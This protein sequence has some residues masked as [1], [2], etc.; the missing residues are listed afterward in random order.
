[1]HTAGR[2]E[3]YIVSL[4]GI[5]K[6]QCKLGSN[7]INSYL[8]TKNKRFLPSVVL[9]CDHCHQSPLSLQNADTCFVVSYYAS[10]FPDALRILNMS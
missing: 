10:A 7:A 6:N 4:E 2:K 1:M 3:K 9:Q 5:N 8:K